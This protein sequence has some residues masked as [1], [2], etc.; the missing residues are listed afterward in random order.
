MR[1]NNTI[2]SF[3]I[4]YL[5]WKLIFYEQNKK[6]QAFI[7]ER[8]TTSTQKNKINHLLNIYL[9]VHKSSILKCKSL[10]K[11][12]ET[13][14]ASSS[15]TE[16]WL[17]SKSVLVR[18]NFSINRN[19]SSRISFRTKV[20]GKFM[21][22]GTDFTTFTNII[23]VTGVEIGE[24]PGLRIAFSVKETSSISIGDSIVGKKPETR[25][26]TGVGAHVSTSWCLGC[27]YMSRRVQSVLLSIS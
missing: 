20:W 26:R 15:S 12:H 1:F 18:H 16:S 7:V 14:L 17:D 23:T 4:N 6:F 3:R 22:T 10:S 8:K 11:M 5:S 2:Q 9:M 25:V 24:W 27:T 19:L 13:P 21:Q